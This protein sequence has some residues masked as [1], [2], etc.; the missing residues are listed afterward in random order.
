MPR[1]RRTPTA[2]RS[3]V[4]R[5]ETVRGRVLGSYLLT[6]GAVRAVAVNN[7]ETPAPGFWFWAYATTVALVATAGATLLVFG[8]RAGERS[9]LA[10]I[11]LAD[12][13]AVV[14][15]LGDQDPANVRSVVTLLLPLTL[16]TAVFLGRRSQLVQAVAVIICSLLIVA[17]DTTSVAELVGL[18]GVPIV[19]FLG[20]AQVVFVLRE[21]LA[22]ALREAEVTALTDPLTGLLNRRG[23]SGTLPSLWRRAE[24]SRQHLAVLLIDLDHFKAVNDTYGHAVGDQV[25]SQV[26]RGLQGA[27]GAGEVIVRLGGEE[28]AVV[29][30][31]ARPAAVDLAERLRLAAHTWLAPWSGSISV[32]VVTG[33]PLG[34]ESQDEHFW[35]LAGLADEA[36]YEAKVAGRD[37]VV[38]HAAGAGA[39]TGTGGRP[40]VVPSP[41]TGR[42]QRDLGGLPDQPG[43]GVDRAEHGSR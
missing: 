24:Q 1:I 42:D 6:V 37:R 9:L 40:P 12:A 14:V 34:A 15:V 4:D 18:A 27:L 28:F 3:W 11:G 33:A 7:P 8:R 30:V 10:A 21:G 20:T 13:A 26:A 32:G 39:P 41:R 25:L 38:V 43:D 5:P 23:L 2:R 31:A 17:P 35:R 22:Q 29:T 19:G 36:L 16:F